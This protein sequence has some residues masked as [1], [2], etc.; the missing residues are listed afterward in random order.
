MMTAFT[1]DDFEDFLDLI[2][3]SDEDERD[4][5]LSE[6]EQIKD[7]KFLDA[8][9]KELIQKLNQE[10][11]SDVQG[12]LIIALG[13]MRKGKKTLR[14]YTSSKTVKNSWVRRLAVAALARATK[15]DQLLPVMRSLISYED[16][17]EP[18]RAVALRILVENGYEK[19]YAKQLEE[20]FRDHSTQTIACESFRQP[21]Y[22]GGT[23]SDEMIVNFANLLVEQLFD[24][25]APDDCQEEAVWALAEL[26]VAY[27]DNDRWSE[28][29][30][31]FAKV[32]GSTGK[33]SLKKTCIEVIE[34]LELTDAAPALSNLLDESDNEI[35]G[36]V[37]QTLFTLLGKDGATN[38][39]VEN[40]ID[41]ESISLNV[42][43]Q[44]IEALRK[45]DPYLAF[46][47]LVDYL[48]LESDEGKKE[49]ITKA[50]E[51]LVNQFP[52]LH[53]SSRRKDAFD[54][55]TSFLEQ[56]N[57]EL[58]GQFHHLKWQTSLAFSSHIVIFILVSLLALSV[59]LYSLYRA[60]S[61]T[62]T[63]E[64]FT[65]QVATA[66]V[67][68]I[69]L[70]FL[71]ARNPL[72]SSRKTITDISKSAIILMGYLRQ[73]NQIDA[74]FKQFVLNN[75]EF[76]SEEMEKTITYLQTAMESSIDGLSQILEEFK[77]D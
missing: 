43:N 60:F 27:P 69:V 64:S 53:L 15:N 25:N 5:T 29:G 2:Q 8:I 72:S 6:L 67:S 40:L 37:T 44:Y 31:D 75:N 68:L 12:Y 62:P 16:G 19:E 76:A 71:F 73:I 47:M 35:R 61:S 28:L 1:S 54:A 41:Y 45:L 55:Y 20:M 38:V 56:T 58:I 57:S 33:T 26:K 21:F 49:R 24:L 9:A 17:E 42:M 30:S 65:F 46:Q 52:A 3:S 34:W 66:I 13:A 77:V 74:A 36:Q 70:F 39:I 48:Y 7:K 23:F 4:S 11:D 14:K 63:N 51:A 50:L 32:L 59:L 22:A 18:V 10:R